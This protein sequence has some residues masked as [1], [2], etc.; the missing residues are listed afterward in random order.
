V[1]ESLTVK[2]RVNVLQGEMKEA[3]K[4]RAVWRRGIKK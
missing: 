4:K 1:K 3:K 2:T